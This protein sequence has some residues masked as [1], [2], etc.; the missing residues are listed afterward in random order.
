MSGDDSMIGK[1]LVKGRLVINNPQIETCRGGTI[2]GGRS[3]GVGGGW[4]D[5]KP[6]SPANMTIIL[7]DAKHDKPWK[8][9]PSN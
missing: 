7:N 8:K 4:G 3:E 5:V 1:S 2:W 9:E 6:R